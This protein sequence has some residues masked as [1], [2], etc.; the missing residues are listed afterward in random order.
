MKDFKI[1]LIGLRFFLLLISYITYK[2]S[3]FICLFQLFMSTCV[4]FKIIHHSMDFVVLILVH[5]FLQGGA[6]S[7]YGAKAQEV[8]GQVRGRYDF[9]LFINLLVCLVSTHNS[10]SLY[11]PFCPINFNLKFMMWLG[12]YFW[13]VIGIFFLWILK[14]LPINIIII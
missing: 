12:N 9:S 4:I 13:A 6:D 7:G 2:N 3:L 8:L 11:L 14:F 5:V 1:I 10:L